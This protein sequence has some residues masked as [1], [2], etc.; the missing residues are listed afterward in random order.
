MGKAGKKDP[1]AP[2]LIPEDVYQRARKLVDNKVAAKQPKGE[3]TSEEWCI[4][5]AM[6]SVP[7]FRQTIRFWQNCAIVAYS[8]QENLKVPTRLKTVES[9]QVL[10]KPHPR[11]EIQDL[12]KYLKTSSKQAAKRTGQF[13]KQ[14]EKKETKETKRE[15][16]L[17]QI[18][19]V[20][21]QMNEELRSSRRFAETQQL[22]NKKFM[23]GSKLF[24][25]DTCPVPAK[26]ALIVCEI[27][28]KQA[29][30]VDEMKDEVLKLLN[31]VI[32]EE[33][34]TFN[35]ATFSSG[36]VNTWCPQYQPKTDPKKG[37]PDALKWLN[38]NVT[39]KACNAQPFP[40]DYATMISRFT[41]EG[42][43]P[44]MRIFL[45]CSRAP[46]S[47]A[48]ATVELVAQLRQA[49]DPP[50]KGQPV[51]PINVVAFDPS[52]VANAEEQN[53]LQKLAGPHGSYMFDTSAEDLMALDKMLKAVQLKKK[54][55]DKLQKKLDKMEDLSEKVAE[56]RRLLQV[57]MALQ[58]M[59]VSDFEVAD[60]ALK[61]D[62]P[63]LVPEI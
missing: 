12:C 47:S 46:D 28:D 57:Q 5:P 42:V 27:S 36:G 6:H 52:I 18:A 59:L 2:T 48:Q 26:N 8:E 45:C 63:I 22:F 61:Y 4:P 44:P 25:P 9:D 33:T 43:T 34:E 19:E 41:S 37:L 15:L 60:W 58:S 50:M 20:D 14:L 30:W 51:L 21:N 29:T 56:D 32:S 3:L 11:K 53:F 7:D 55:L 1:N 23:L 54:Q 31:G 38:K 49:L 16:L 24:D 13:L 39:A 10:K 40:P 35:I 17:A 62:P